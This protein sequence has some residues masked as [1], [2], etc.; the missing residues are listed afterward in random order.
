M[1]RLLVL[2]HDDYLAVLTAAAKHDTTLFARLVDAPKVRDAAPNEAW[3][4][5]KD[6]LA[7]VRAAV[8]GAWSSR[9]RLC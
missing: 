4:W 6:R 8:E 1:D 9:S 7:E 3:G 5:V 2:S